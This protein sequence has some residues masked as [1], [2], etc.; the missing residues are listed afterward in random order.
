M[1]ANN[2]PIFTRA[3][4]VQWSPIINV[5]HNA[6]DLTSGTS[7]LAFTADAAEGGY[8]QELRLKPA[9]GTSTT[10]T[11]LR[12]WINN[13]ATLAT[14]TNTTLW[15]EFAIPATTT[16]TVNAQS[17]VSVA[18]GFALPLGH[19]IYVTISAYATGGFYATVVGGKY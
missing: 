12:V 14:A 7:Y 13:G 15:G 10:A 16:S 4:D 2:K 1:A 18:L 19:K 5:A 3:G 8:V 6:A 9:P 17:D 11:V